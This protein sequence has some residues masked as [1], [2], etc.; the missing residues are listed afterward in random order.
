VN[1]NDFLTAVLRRLDA[2][3]S[4]DRKMNATEAVDYTTK[5]VLTAVM[6]ELFMQGFFE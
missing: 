2:V 6:D 5:M 3:E 1:R 4:S